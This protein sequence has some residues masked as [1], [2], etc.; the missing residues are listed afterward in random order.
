MCN[1]IINIV[2]N[3]MISRVITP[4]KRSQPTGR[5]ALLQGHHLRDVLLH[6]AEVFGLHGP[7]PCQVPQLRLQP[8][9][10]PLRRHEP[11]QWPSP[12]LQAG[13]T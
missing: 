2:Y 1:I 8:E 10:L 3:F 11:R 4:Q 5:N 13:H 7:A 9:P 6:R 12:R